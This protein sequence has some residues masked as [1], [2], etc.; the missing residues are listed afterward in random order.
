MSQLCNNRLAGTVNVNDCH[1][2]LTRIRKSSST[3][4]VPSGLISESVMP[5]MNNATLCAEG[6]AQFCRRHIV[7]RQG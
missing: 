2:A 7:S 5:S 6:S 4:S 3:N 1:H